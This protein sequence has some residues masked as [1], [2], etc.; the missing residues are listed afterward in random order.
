MKKL[1]AVLAVAALAGAA[2]A[3]VF[4]TTGHAA[5]NFIPFGAG[6][7]GTPTMHQ[8]F[9]DALFGASPVEITSI[10]FSPGTAGTFDLGQV[11]IRMGYSNAAPLF[12]GIP[13]QGGGGAPNAAG[14]MSVFY[15]APSVFTINAAGNENFTEMR[16]NGSFV[17]DPGQGDLLIE[18]VAPSAGNTS[19]SVSRAAASAESTRAYDGMSFAAN[20]NINA[21]RFD[22]DFQ[23]A[24]GGPIGPGAYSVQSNGDDHLYRINLMTGVATDLGL[25]GLN[26]AE[27][28]SDGPGD[29]LFAIGGTVEEFWNITSTPGS[30][31]GATG[32]LGGIDSGLDW[33]GTTMWHAGANTGATGTLI[34]RV[35]PATGAVTNVSTA[36]GVFFDNIAV[37]GNGMAYGVDG[38]F[39]DSLYRVNPNTGATTLVG[40][41]GLGDISVQVGTSFGPGGRLFALFSD[42]NIYTIDTNTGAATFQAAVTV[43]GVPTGGWEGLGI[44]GGGGN[45]ELFVDAGPSATSQTFTGGNY[46]AGSEFT[47]STARMCNVLGYI[48]VEGDGLTESHQI[49]LWDANTQ[50]LL[51]QVT[52]TPTSDTVPTAGGVGQWFV[53]NIPTINLPAGTYRVAGI[54]GNEANSLSDDKVSPAGITLASGYV[55]TDFPSGGFAF[56]GLSFT[57]EAVRSTAGFRGGM[58]PA[59]EPDLTTGA[60]AGQPGYGVPNGILNNDDFFYY[61]AQFAAGNLAVAD[62]TTGAIAGQPGYGVPNGILNNDDFFYYLAIFAAGC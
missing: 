59:C 27:G 35:N 17:Y 16:F 61:L 5:Q 44:I 18:I 2:S 55:R 58:P 48:D 52:V 10:G 46:V 6:G 24:G 37:D 26:D 28:V 51:A 15:N 45:S 56:P 38:I 30:L 39:T 34:N 29:R 21:T 1:S 41:L 20:A 40:N 36:A 31:V 32:P 19:M 57:S 53:E 49:G 33:D 8:V 60:I 47:L 11:T 4:P 14:P 7:A 3:Q 43:G 25:I 50:A 22:F 9:D 23:P 12:L 54:V 42:G 13:V 62:L